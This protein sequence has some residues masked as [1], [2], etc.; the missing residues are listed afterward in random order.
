[1]SLTIRRGD[2][3]EFCPECGT[4]LILTQKTLKNEVRTFLTCSQCNYQRDITKSE[5]VFSKS[6]GRYS[7]EQ[8]AVIDDAIANIR[9]MP[10]IKIECPKCGNREAFWWFVQTRGAEES[11]TQFFRCTTCMHTWREMT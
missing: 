9:T 10:K 11:P 5:T 2:I 1:M 7:T 6:M 8:I 4:R 3:M